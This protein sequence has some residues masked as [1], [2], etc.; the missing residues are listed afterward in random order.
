MKET[1]GLFNE[2]HK[3]LNRKIKEDIRKWKRAP[4]LMDQQNQYC[5]NCYI[6][7]SNLHVQCNPHQNSNSFFTDTEKSIL[8]FLWRHKR[9]QI[10]KAILSKMSSARDITIP[11]L[12]LY[13][14]AITIK[15]AWY[16]DKNR[17][18]DQWDRRP[19]H[20]STWL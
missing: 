8:K 12:K 19:R 2:N 7:K 3:S 18:E 16:W 9:P 11:D 1:K 5:E 15:T 17:H 10:A 13:Y 6:T 4:T 20:K 14:R